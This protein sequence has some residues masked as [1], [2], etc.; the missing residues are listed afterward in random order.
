MNSKY[1]IILSITALALAGILMFF[2]LADRKSTAP[3]FPEGRVSEIKIDE[4]KIDDGLSNIEMTTNAG[5]AA[6]PEVVS[7]EA[8]IATPASK[9]AYENWIMYAA[10]RWKLSLSHADLN[11]LQG[12]Y[13]DI[14]NDRLSYENQIAEVR[15]ISRSEV[16][17]IIPEYTGKGRS[18]KQRYEQ[19]VITAFGETKAQEV[20]DKIGGAIDSTNYHFGAQSQVIT[21]EY[22]PQSKG[23]A[24]THWVS[25]GF[26]YH[27]INEG[28][29]SA[30]NYFKNKF[31]RLD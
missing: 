16:D 9:A 30:Y 12:I 2:K 10:N 3:S 21:I 22:L 5:L 19:S 13:N 27:T 7:R 31:P 28:H 24:V 17:I 4:G 6:S 15:T 23:F 1:I 14:M 20:F 8:S 11:I 26:T 29:S 25:G 18:L